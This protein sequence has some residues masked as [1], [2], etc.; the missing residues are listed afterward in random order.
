[1]N[2]LLKIGKTFYCRLPIPK[3]LQTHYAA[4]EV[5]RSLHTKCRN[6]AKQ[7]LA[8]IV[9]DYQH[10]FFVLRYTMKN[11]PPTRQALEIFGKMY[12]DL[13]AEP[14]MNFNAV[15][16]YVAIWPSL[17]MSIMDALEL[18]YKPNSDGVFVIPSPSISI[19]EALRRG[20]R[21]DK[22]GILKL[23]DT[24]TPHILP[25]SP[26]SPTEA[27]TPAST[28]L[29][30]E[31]I[32]EFIHDKRHGTSK[33]PARSKKTVDAYERTL[34]NFSY[35]VGKCDIVTASTKTNDFGDE[36]LCDGLSKD[37]TNTYLRG[38]KSFY[39]WCTT[40]RGTKYLTTL[41]SIEYCTLS[42][43]ELL[44]RGNRTYN[45]EEIQA[46]L[47]RL[48][49][50]GD[51]TIEGR[52]RNLSFVFYCLTLLFS[53]F[54][55][56]EAI[57]LERTD[58][59]DINSIPVIDLSIDKI[60]KLK[61]LSAPRIIPIHKK[62]LDLH[63]LE[64]VGNARDSVFNYSYESYRAR[65][66]GILYELKI[67]T[68]PYEMLFHSMRHGFDTSLSTIGTCQDSHRRMLVGHGHRGM[69]K[70][71]LEIVNH[72]VPTFNESVQKMSFNYD[73]S[74]LKEYLRE[75]LDSLYRP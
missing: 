47:N 28:V 44:K 32:E 18:G 45:D 53:G 71:Y 12:P 63:I 14:I 5:K 8:R 22:D 37:S 50:R 23:P 64:F 62:L 46:L 35:F 38:I 57:I 2:Y 54:R 6:E 3:E 16:Q 17:L 9:S 27:T 65:L 10:Q 39:E 21:A 19:G 1:M 68:K 56:E 48:A 55:K 73:F 33:T 51:T 4:V 24:A 66:N 69:D 75:E 15:G 60:S 74:K 70:V 20:Y 49:V 13:S 29:L 31:A 59:T 7:L 26:A 42:D 25:H 11:R 61:N 34:K 72:H 41:P 36:L 52:K 58:F 40:K 30:S 43:E 67:K